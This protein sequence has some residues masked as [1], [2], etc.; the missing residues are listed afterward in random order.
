M[1]WAGKEPGA[2]N[3]RRCVLSGKILAVREPAGLITS[4]IA[5][6][7]TLVSAASFQFATMLARTT[8]CAKS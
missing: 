5:R 1:T 7:D 6:K 4:A 2:I 8:E 3:L